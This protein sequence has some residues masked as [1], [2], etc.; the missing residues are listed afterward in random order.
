M[1][2]SSSK[3]STG[4]SYGSNK[5]GTPTEDFS[6]SEDAKKQIFGFLLSLAG[7]L[8]FLSVIS[9]SVKDQAALERFSFFEM[10]RKE[11]YGAEIYNWL[12]AAG[13]IVSELL[14]SKLFGYFSAAIPI[15]IALYGGLLLFK[16]KFPRIIQFSIYFLLLMVVTA[17]CAGLLKIFMGSDTIPSRYSGATGDY[18]STVL[19]QTLGSVGAS[20]L[21][22]MALVL[23]VM[24]VIDGNLPKSM[25]RVSRMFSWIFAKLKG[26][27]KP[28]EETDEA[29]ETAL[30]EEIELSPV[31][32]EKEKIRRSKLGKEDVEEE[33][34]EEPIKETLINRPKNEVHV[35]EEEDDLLT[36]TGSGIGNKL[37]DLKPKDELSETEI[38]PENYNEAEG[39]GS[40]EDDYEEE[41]LDDYETPVLSL[42]DESEDDGDVITDE[43]LTLNGKLLQEK[44]LKFGIEIEKVFATPGPVVTLYELIPAPHI[45]LSKIESLQDDIALAMKAKGIRMIIPI[46]GK[47]TVGVEIPNSVAQMVR[48]KDVLA[49]KKYRETD[50]LLPIAFGK[51]IEGEVFVGDLAK[52]PHV[53]IAGATG[54]GKSVGIN[55]LI[56]SLLYKKHPSDL[57]FVMVD[58]KKIEL[59][60]YTKLKKHF[61]ATSSDINE[62]IV[63]SPS[64]AVSILKSVEME[65]EQRYDKLANAGVRNIEA[66]NKKYEAGEL[67]NNDVLRHRKMPYIVVVIDEL[68]DLMI[69]AKRDIEDPI[70]RIAQMARAVGIHLVVA[71]QRPSVDVITGVIKANFPVRIAYQVASKI[72]SR[73]IID[74]GGADK[75][76]RNGDMLY[77]SSNSPK[78]IRIQNAYISTE[79]CEK[80]VEFIGEQQGFSRSYL[81]PSIIERRSHSTSGMEDQDELFE[82]A[83]RL[84]LK[85]QVCSTSTLQRRL[86]L[87]YA[88]A[89]RIVDQ[90]EDAGIV[91]P[92]QGAKGREIMITEDELE[93]ILH[94]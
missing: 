5:K 10:F 53:L 26:L 82:E 61:L 70:A 16:K 39:S 54:S 51:T 21:L 63:T 65:M 46:P 8:V 68:A 42:L 19:Y 50:K 79:E 36:G 28:K 66:Y 87:G 59:S 76:L 40:D 37:T 60:L 67:R 77:L 45:K 12:G 31:E 14:V 88:R 56:A 72:D 20:V 74:M 18:I 83:A 57:K 32:Q 71:T 86:K 1:A 81:L 80:V 38:N 43:E 90:M 34:K 64:N 23:N 3:R 75:L 93:E 92:N 13:A 30:E 29:D 62:S 27:R 17:S 9:Y 94:S 47:G 11:T 85:L 35:E 4:K 6:I 41:T 52:M 7:I 55:T 15:L 48:V 89:A 84:V 24:L 73:T 22:F 44:L 49:S 78:P 2:K 58:P 25:D 33:V 69:T 91:G